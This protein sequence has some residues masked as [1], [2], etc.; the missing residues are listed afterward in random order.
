MTH[1]NFEWDGDKYTWDLAK[2]GRCTLGYIIIF[3]T[4]YHFMHCVMRLL[5]DLTEARD[6]KTEEDSKD[7]SKYSDQENKASQEAASGKTSHSAAKDEGSK[8]K[9]KIS[10]DGSDPLGKG[11]TCSSMQNDRLVEKK[12]DQ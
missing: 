6:A 7:V 10:S 2:A 9:E 1:L 11:T 4:G 12:K 8:T 3:V 5:G